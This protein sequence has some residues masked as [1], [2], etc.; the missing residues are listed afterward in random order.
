M[1]VVAD[2][3]VVSKEP[4]PLYLPSEYFFLQKLDQSSRVRKT[5]NE[6]KETHGAWKVAGGRAGV[7]LAL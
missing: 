5:W 2:C 7:L 6:D 3:F 4:F 1:P